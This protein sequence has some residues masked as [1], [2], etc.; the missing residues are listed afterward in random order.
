MDFNYFC[1]KFT[2][3]EEIRNHTINLGVC[4]VCM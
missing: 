3:Y 4:V 1:I 2:K